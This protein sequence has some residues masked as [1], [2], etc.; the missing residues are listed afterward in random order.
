MKNDIHEFISG[1]ALFA[2]LPKNEMALVADEM[3]EKKLPRR[4][5]LAV[6]GRTELDCVYIIKSGRMELFYETHGEKN[7]KGVLEPGETFGGVSILMNAG[8]SVRTVQVL[9][10]ATVYALPKKLFLEICTRNKEFYE[11]FAGRFRKEMTNDTYA[12]IVA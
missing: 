1:I 3:V 8:F 7:I 2:H 9:A 10:D 11:Y 6:Q 12:S 5:I 4:T